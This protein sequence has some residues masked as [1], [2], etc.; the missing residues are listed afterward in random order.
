MDFIT[1]F[2]GRFHP[3]IVHLPIGI[4]FLAFIFECLA[5]R[6]AYKVLR[7]AVQPALL[8]GTVFAI[9]AAITGYFLRQEG[10]YEEDIANRHQNFGILTAVLS[11]V[12]YVLRPKVKYWIDHPL[13]KHQVIAALSVPLL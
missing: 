8:M 5:F 4:L 10:G 12:V 2:F 3:L 9:A 13:R 6:D 7:K 1:A 11:L